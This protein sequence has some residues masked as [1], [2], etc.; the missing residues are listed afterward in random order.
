MV[1]LAELISELTRTRGSNATTTG[2]PFTC[3]PPYCTVE[4]VTHI[5][6]AALVILLEY[7][8]EFVWGDNL[9]FNTKIEGV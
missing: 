1:K 3:T 2:L 8:G 5:S 4:N 6:N 9:I 7:D